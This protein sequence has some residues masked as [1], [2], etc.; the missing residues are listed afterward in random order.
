MKKTACFL[1]ILTT[2]FIHPQC[3]R[4]DFIT[5]LPPAVTLNGG[6]AEILVYSEMGGGMYSRDIKGDY[7]SLHGVNLDTA[8]IQ[9]YQ[10]RLRYGFT[11][12]FEGMLTVPLIYR[13]DAYTG[14]LALSGGG[15]GD[16][17]FILRAQF[18]D[19]KK[20]TFRMCFGGGLKVP[21]GVSRWSDAADNE[22]VTSDNGA[23][24]FLSTL[25][26][27]QRIDPWE[28]FLGAGLSLPFPYIPPK[29]YGQNIPSNIQ[30]FYQP[31]TI[32]NM[33]ASLAYHLDNNN[34]ISLET[35]GYYFSDDVHLGINPNGYIDNGNPSYYTLYAQYAKML[36]DRAEIASGAGYDI[37][38]K[39]GLGYLRFFLAATV[40]I[41]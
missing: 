29:L 7:N 37:V 27:S 41:N 4:A 30:T 24:E 17:S 6:E 13:Q 19:P 14:G 32:F 38:I 8:A 2:W 20:S 36:W 28:Y 11:R 23:F 35:V 3:L 34:V 16:M 21:S 15:L 5:H 10:A 9:Q 40:W 1:L 31:G 33:G 25:G 12:E 22:E 26:I 18:A 39:N